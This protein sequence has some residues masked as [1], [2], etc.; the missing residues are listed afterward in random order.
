MMMMMIFM[1]LHAATFV[2]CLPRSSLSIVKAALPV[3]ENRQCS[4]QDARY[5][6]VSNFQLFNCSTYVSY[7]Y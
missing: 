3:V 1:I 6:A 7:V 5:I 4:Q 2:K